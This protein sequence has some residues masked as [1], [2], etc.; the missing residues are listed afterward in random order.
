MTRRERLEGQIVRLMSK[1]ERRFKHDGKVYL[2]PVIIRTVEDMWMSWRENAFDRTEQLLLVA[3][4][5]IEREAKKF[6]RDRKR[7]VERQREMA[8]A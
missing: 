3:G 2:P 4:L 5:L 7:Y 8:T 1:A 6:A